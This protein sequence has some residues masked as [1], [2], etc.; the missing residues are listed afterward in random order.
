MSHNRTITQDYHRQETDEETESV[1]ARSE[2]RE[3]V[4]DI[5]DLDE[6]KRQARLSENLI[7]T[8]GQSVVYFSML[9]VIILFFI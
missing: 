8:Q 1:S 9:M 4:P 7:E 2:E 5:D 6:M 3:S